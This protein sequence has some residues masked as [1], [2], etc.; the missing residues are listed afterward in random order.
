MIPPGLATPSNNFV[1]APTRKGPGLAAGQSAPA[2]AVARLAASGRVVHPTR[3]VR[4]L[5]PAARL[6]APASAPG[7]P[8]RSHRLVTARSTARSQPFA[9]FGNGA[10]HRRRSF[11]A[12]AGLISAR[13]IDGVSSEGYGLAG[14]PLGRAGATTSYSCHNLP[15]SGKGNRAL[16]AHF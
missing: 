12:T 1:T 14:F 10:A 6:T 4:L 3:R 8:D 9:P 11:F 2:S 5:F 15:R 7:P 13:N 16:V